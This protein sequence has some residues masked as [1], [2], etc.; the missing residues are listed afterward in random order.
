MSYLKIQ[1]SSSTQRRTS[2]DKDVFPG[3]QN[4][5]HRNKYMLQIT[6]E[7]KC[8]IIVPNPES[9]AYLGKAEI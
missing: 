3:D 9:Y 1:K 7:E 5:N 8:R 4:R 6:R 2:G